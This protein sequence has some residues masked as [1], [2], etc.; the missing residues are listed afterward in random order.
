MKTTLFLATLAFAAPA[1]AESE[2]EAGLI[3]VCLDAG[4]DHSL[5]VDC[6]DWAKRVIIAKPDAAAYLAECKSQLL[7]VQIA[8]QKIEVEA[9][10]RVTA[11]R[12][13]ILAKEAADA[14]AAHLAYVA[15]HAAKP[16]KHTGI[17]SLFTK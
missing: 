15:E 12:D 17:F 4:M 11:E 7:N 10:K 9:L 8:N 3:G 6:V 13:A 5:D 1:H 16:A 14:H 2:L